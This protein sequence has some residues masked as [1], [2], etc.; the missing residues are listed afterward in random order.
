[1]IR[2]VLA[3][4]LV[5]LAAPAVGEVTP[6]PGPGDPHLQSVGYDPEQ[7]VALRVA[8]GFAVTVQLSPDER[9]ETISVGNSVA[10]Q[11]QPN[12]RGD[13]VFVKLASGGSPS[14]LTI[15]T[16]VRRY[17][18]TLYPTTS[19][20]RQ[21]AYALRFIYPVAERVPETKVTVESTRYRLRGDR[22]L[23]P[24]AMS[25]DGSFTSIAWA[26][27]T[28]LPAVYLVDARNREAL[29][30]GVVRDGAYVIEGVARRMVFKLGKARATATRMAPKAEQP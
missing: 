7:V 29:V 15:L 1:M 18:F 19:D 22:S 17:S 2:S 28:A 27:D 11:V 8:P 21:L 6:I 23:W 4:S 25:D 14:N 3:A 5:L 24:I 26:P 16:D 13:V 9:V 30:N 20:D 10:W 12:K